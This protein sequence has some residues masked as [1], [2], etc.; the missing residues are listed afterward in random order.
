MNY[1]VVNGQVV[2]GEAELTGAHPGK[3]LL[4]N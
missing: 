1:V 4:R 3:I 2:I